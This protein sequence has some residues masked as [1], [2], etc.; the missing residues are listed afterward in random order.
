MADSCEYRKA[1]ELF[2]QQVN[3]TPFPHSRAETELR[4]GRIIELGR[5]WETSNFYDA[6]FR[7]GVRQRGAFSMMQVAAQKEAATGRE[8][9]GG[10]SI[11][12]SAEPENSLS[13]PW[14]SSK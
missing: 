4:N 5:Q 7:L 9:R 10:F 8:A 14:G 3:N 13:E 11:G 1:A 6:P 2:G 12:G